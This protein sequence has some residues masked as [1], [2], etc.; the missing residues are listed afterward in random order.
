MQRRPIIPSNEFLGLE[1]TAHLCCGGEAPF[2]RRHLEACQR[3]AVDKSDGMAGRERFFAVYDRAKRLLGER[4][5][6]PPA[7]IALLAHAS[8]GLNQVA[9]TIDWRPGD[10][11]VVTDVEFPSDVYPF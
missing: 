6:V 1:A 10:N 4:L 7:T 5:G 11:V 2:M 3:F 9:R 8:E